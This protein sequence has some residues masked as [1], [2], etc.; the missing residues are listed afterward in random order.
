VIGRAD[1]GDALDIGGP[2]DVVW[3][4]RPGDRERKIGAD[5]GGCEQQRLQRRLAIG[6]PG[7]EV[8][9]RPAF[10][11]REPRTG[12]R[13]DRTVERDRALGVPPMLERFEGGAGRPA[14]HLGDV[15]RPVGDA[16]ADDHRIG[17]GDFRGERG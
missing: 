2:V 5:T 11:A 13:I 16:A 8:G 6:G 15:G 9:E 7:A 3:I 4:E 1:V 17:A 12:L 14:L 10:G